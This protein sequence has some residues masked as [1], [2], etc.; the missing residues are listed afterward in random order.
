MTAMHDS[1]LERSEGIVKVTLS[2]MTQK[3]VL[4]FTLDV[5]KAVV[6]LLPTVYRPDEDI[7]STSSRPSASERRHYTLLVLPYPE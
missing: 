6:S 2:W 1:W 3:V 5:S 4:L 7:D